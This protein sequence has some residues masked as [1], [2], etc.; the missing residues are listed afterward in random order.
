MWFLLAAAC[1]MLPRANSVAQSV[2]SDAIESYVA[3]LSARDHF[4]RNGE[5]LQSPAAII[6]QD[7]ANYYLYGY[8]DPEDEPDRFFSSKENRARLERLLEGG[9]TTPQARRIIVNGTPLIRVDIY[10]DFVNVTVI[11]G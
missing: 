1:L 10:E 5:G 4:N 7:R 9:R 3:R 6:R 8:R 11:S 2:T